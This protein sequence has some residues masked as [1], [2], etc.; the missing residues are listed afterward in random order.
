A[1]FEDNVVV[2]HAAAQAKDKVAHASI[3]A[4][5][6]VWVD[7]AARPDPRRPGDEDGGVDER[8]KAVPRYV[9]QAWPAIRGDKAGRGVCLRDMFGGHHGAPVQRVASLV[10]VGTDAPQEVPGLL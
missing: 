4:D 2:D 7:D 9:A 1:V 5:V 6:A 8:D 3:G 10:A